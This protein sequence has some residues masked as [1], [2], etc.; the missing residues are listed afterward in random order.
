VTM[1]QMTR[2]ETA[3]A[4]TPA[5]RTR[6]Q[7]QE[8]AVCEVCMYLLFNGFIVFFCGCPIMLILRGDNNREMVASEKERN[9]IYRQK[10]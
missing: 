9:V 8:D 5:G 7:R 10:P 2:T 4:S 1:N 3:A 6:H